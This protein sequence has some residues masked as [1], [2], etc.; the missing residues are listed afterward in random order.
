[1]KAEDTT[2][3]AISDGA[4]GNERQALALAGA[5][6]SDPCNVHIDIDAP[7]RWLAP[8]LVA[9]SRRAV[10]GQGFAEPWPALAVGCGRLA[11]LATR[12]LAGWA[13]GRC[14]R[15]QIL[16]PRI[17]PRHY[18]LVVAPRHD[19]LVGPNVIVTT[20][21]LNPIDDA[22]LAA[23]RT[24]FTAFGA[25]PAPRTAVLV[26]ASTDA[27]AIDTGYVDALQA[28]L[29]RLHARDGGSFLV[30]TSRR[31]PAALAAG[32]RNTFARWPGLFW[33][34]DADGVNPYAG[35]LAWAD[36]IVVTPDSVNMLSEA[37]ATGVPV[38]SLVRTPLHGKLARFHAEL[39]GLGHLV[40]FGEP[41][42]ATAA[43]RE[44]PGVAAIV[45]EHWTA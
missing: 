9:G 32:L 25:L 37:C 26:G 43:L 42:R 20:G 33:A 30:T 36:R 10:H 38:H 15:V 6:C 17:H 14:L 19:D 1:M 4:A 5:L 27:Q 29:S 35:L 2:A 3:W 24:R 31:T 8:R 22:W 41:S 12:G 13:G 18:D 34:G 44:L 11:A 7:W 28:E 23:A 21:A 39:A 45:R 40:A 16:D